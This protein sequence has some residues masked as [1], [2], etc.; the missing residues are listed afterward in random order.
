MPYIAH[1][2]KEWGGVTTRQ[3][4]TASCLEKPRPQVSGTKFGEGW[5]CSF[6]DMLADKHAT[7]HLF[8]PEGGVT[9]TIRQSWIADSAPALPVVSQFE[10][11]LRCLIY[12]AVS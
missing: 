9:I 4:W 2:N 10:Y 7:I 5:M 12:A 1:H 3:P 8:P 6:G 11:M